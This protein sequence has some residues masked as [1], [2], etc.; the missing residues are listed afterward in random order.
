MSNATIHAVVL[1]G[2]GFGVSSCYEIGILKALCGTG[3]AHLD[4]LPVDP[5]IYSGAV[6][7]AFNAA[8]MTSQKDFDNPARLEALERIWLEEITGRNDLL[9]RLGLPRQTGV[10]RLRFNPRPF[11]DPF[12]LLRDP[13][14][15]FAELAAD[16]AYVTRQVGERVQ[17]FLGSRGRLLHRLLRIPALSDFFD[18]EPL[19]ALLEKHIDLELIRRS[20]R[21][22]RVVGTDW[23][24]GDAAVYRQ[25]E[26]TYEMLMASLAIFALFPRREIGDRP[27]AGGGIATPTPIRPAIEA[28][29]ELGAGK[30]IL[31]VIYLRPRLEDIPVEELPSTLETFNRLTYLQMKGLALDVSDRKRVPRPSDK[32]PMHVHFYRPARHLWDILDVLNYDRDEAREFIHHGTEDGLAHDCAA[33]GCGLI[34]APARLG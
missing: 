13:L 26:L 2:S 34:D 25:S 33:A 5:Q 15:P 4:N 31:H 9:S 29:V 24:T 18:T 23:T 32:L 20:G 1:T 8:V 3:C 16:T 19:E 14:H 22:L 17:G 10:Y 6:F 30:L 28:A 12:A 21:E 7:G 11:L 27:I